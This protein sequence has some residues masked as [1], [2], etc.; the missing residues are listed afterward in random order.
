MSTLER[1][2][3]QTKKRY[4]RERQ[5]D[6][7]MP[8]GRRGHRSYTHSRRRGMKLGPKSRFINQMGGWSQNARS[9]TK[10]EYIDMISYPFSRQ[11][12]AT[13]GDYD[14]D[15]KISLAPTNPPWPMDGVGAAFQ[16]VR[17]KKVELYITGVEVNDATSLSN[18]YNIQV[19][20]AKWKDD[21]VGDT[22]LNMVPGAQTKMFNLPN[23]GGNNSREVPTQ[24]ETEVMRIA[25]MY[26]PLNARVE[27]TGLNEVGEGILS[28]S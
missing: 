8:K 24:G 23:V 11:I 4:I 17:P 19:I 10:H 25:V 15:V 1:W 12:I 16:M 6:L 5:E 3:R 22:P 9:T 18:L 21:G 26:P 14:H 27:K 7:G 20:V 28:S 13:A 2:Y